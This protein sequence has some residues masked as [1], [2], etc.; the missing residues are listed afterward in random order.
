MS[1]LAVKPKVAK[2]SSLKKKGQAAFVRKVV[3]D[4][5]SPIAAVER[6]SVFPLSGESKVL[7]WPKL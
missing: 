5:L 2:L 1:K 3:A 6:A 7:H 4:K